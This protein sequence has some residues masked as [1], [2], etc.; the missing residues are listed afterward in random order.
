MAEKES[1][2]HLNNTDDNGKMETDEGKSLF[3]KDTNIFNP[4]WY[5]KPFGLK[6]STFSKFLDESGITAHITRVLSDLYD[7]PEKPPYPIHY[8]RKHFGYF[9]PNT[10]N[11]EF[12]IEFLREIRVELNS[13]REQ[14][15]YLKSVFAQ[16]SDINLVPLEF[17]PMK[18]VII[19]STPESYS[20]QEPFWSSTSTEIVD[21]ERRKRTKK[22]GIGST[23]TTEE[24]LGAYKKIEQM[25]KLQK[26]MRT[27]HK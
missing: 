6:K 27:L 7:T 23:T 1:K 9:D 18:K 3:R 16:Y 20:E 8:F 11:V 21:T 5:Y 14:N 25:E 22:K 10:P 15:K 2:F 4:Y 12:L 19:S 13:L 17:L 24:D 26:T